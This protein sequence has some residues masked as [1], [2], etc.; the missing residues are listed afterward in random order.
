MLKGHEDRT[1]RLKDPS[2]FLLLIKF[3]PISNSLQFETE[4]FWEKCV[5]K[6]EKDREG[7]ILSFD[8]FCRSAS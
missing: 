3:V 7:E 1:G 8:L 4:K 2:F 6:K 5:R